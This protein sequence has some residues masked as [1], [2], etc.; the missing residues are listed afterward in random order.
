MNAHGGFTTNPPP[1]SESPFLVDRMPLP[2]RSIAY[3]QERVAREYG[4]SRADLL[5]RRKQERVVRPRQ[6]AMYLAARLTG[7]TSITIGTAFGRDR[8]SVTHAIRTVEIFLAEDPEWADEVTALGEALQRELGTRNPLDRT[9]DEVVET[10]RARLKSLARLEPEALIERL[11][12][13]AKLID[14]PPKGGRP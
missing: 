7:Q 6:L 8:T 5:C 11:K 14:T 13:A 4:L 2:S 3:I 1:R 9:I 10:L 12:W